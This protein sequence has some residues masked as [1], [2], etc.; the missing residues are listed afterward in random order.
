MPR[1]AVLAVLLAGHRGHGARGLAA[2][3]REPVAWW[4]FDEV[5]EQASL[6]RASQTADRLEGHH[7]LVEGVAGKAVVFDG[8]TTVLRRASASAPAL[9]DAFTIESWVALGAYPWN[10]VPIVDHGDDEHARLRLRHRP[11]RRAV[12]SRRGRRALARGDVRRLRGVAPEVDA[13][14]GPLRRRGRDLALFVDGRLVAQRAAAGS[15]GA[16]RPQPAPR[17]R[18]SRREVSTC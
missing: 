8:Y 11:A 10:V 5:V 16:R 15:G 4:P 7:R 6:D 9:A 14:R 13:P 3:S 2:R 1:F 18:E 17:P 12:A